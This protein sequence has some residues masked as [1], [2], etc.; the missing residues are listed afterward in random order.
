[1]IYLVGFGPRC[2]GFLYKN[3]QV[4]SYLAKNSRSIS[5]GLFDLSAIFQQLGKTSG[6]GWSDPVFEIPFRP[7]LLNT[8]MWYIIT[9]RGFMIL[10]RKTHSR[11]PLH[12]FL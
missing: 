2:Q 7:P 5:G 8:I 3:S 6:L 11:K 9:L 1:M 10:K 4:I 12:L